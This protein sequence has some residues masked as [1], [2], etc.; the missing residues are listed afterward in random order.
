MIKFSLLQKFKFYIND[1]TYCEIQ[2]TPTHDVIQ[3]CA[4]YYDLEIKVKDGN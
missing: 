2:L 4:F 1:L 3:E